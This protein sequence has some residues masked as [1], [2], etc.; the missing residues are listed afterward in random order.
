MKT[1]IFE[2]IIREGSDEFWEG[3]EAA[4]KTGC[5]EVLEMLKEQLSAEPG[6]EITL[7]EYNNFN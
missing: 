3:L 5:D 1:Y 2:V 6:C 4:D 7:K